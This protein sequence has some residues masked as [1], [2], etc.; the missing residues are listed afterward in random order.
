MNTD[1]YRNAPDGL[2]PLATE[3]KD[4]P[5]RLIYDLVAEVERL[6]EAVKWGDKFLHERDALKVEV[7]RYKAI[8]DRGYPN[9]SWDTLILQLGDAEKERNEALAEV[10]R[11]QKLLWLR[12]DPNHFSILYG[13]DGEMQCS[14]CLIDFKRMDAEKIEAIWQDRALRKLA[15][16]QAKNDQLLEQINNSPRSVKLVCQDCGAT[17]NTVKEGF[18]PFASDVHNRD[19]PVVLCRGCFRE[20][21]YDI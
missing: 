11:L 20:R 8:R 3:W 1:D 17:D 10:E 15:E 6:R 13:D 18:C 4:K 2:G 14:A 16:K 5:H 19:V 12:H 21:A 7:E 9:K